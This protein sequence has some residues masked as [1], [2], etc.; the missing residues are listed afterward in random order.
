MAY[1]YRLAGEDLKLAK[2]E[3]KGFLKSQGI[4]EEIKGN[5]RIAETQS[6]PELLQR[7]ALTH[8]VCEKLEETNCKEIEIDLEV[9]GSFA[10]RCIVLEGDENSKELEKEIGEKI[11]SESNSVD[12]E[13]PK[14]EIYAYVQDNKIILGELNREIDRGLFNKRSNEKRPFS[15]P[16]SLDPVLARALVNLAE[17]PAGGKVLDPFCGT[18]GILIEAG[19]CGILPLGTDTKKEMVKGTRE[20][21]E[22]YGII[23]HQIKQEDAEKSLN[24]FEYKPDAIITDLPYGKASKVEG[25]IEEKFLEIVNNCQEK[26]VFMYDK[27]EIES[28]SADYVIFVHKNLI[29]YIYIES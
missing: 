13:S 3:L 19:L 23:N 5:S 27:P 12:L 7:L 15:S 11:N 17:V 10:V 29:R 8:E 21:L 6:E 4:N 26:T 18:G 24:V 28:Y 20:N 16:V 14:T 9:E 22:E 25:E 2:A 1:V